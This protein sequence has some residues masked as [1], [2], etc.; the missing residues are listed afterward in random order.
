MPK[1]LFPLI[2]KRI[3]SIPTLPVTLH[4]VR[5]A[6]RRD[7]AGSSELA[8]LVE[9]DPALTAKVLRVMNSP[10]YEKRFRMSTL[11]HAVA[12]LG[13]TALGRLAEGIDVFPERD[14]GAGGLDPYAFWE[15]SLAVAAASRAIAREVGYD[16]PEEAYVGGLLHDLGVVVLHLYASEEDFDRVRGEVEGGV[17]VETAERRILGMDHCQVGALV[18]EQWRF[19]RILKDVIQFHHAE[20]SRIRS[21]DGRHQWMVGIVS[22]ANRICWAFGLGSKADAHRRSDDLPGLTGVSLKPEQVEAV[23]DAVGEDLERAL[24]LLEVRPAEGEDALGALRRESGAAAPELGAGSPRPSPASR[25]ALVGEV[26][27]RARRGHNMQD[28]LRTSLSSIQSGLGMDRLI[29]LGLDPDDERL[30]GKYVFDET[31][32]EVEIRGLELPLNPDGVIGAVLRDHRALLVDNWATD[33][34]LLGHLGV[35]EVAAAP[36]IVNQNSL[37]IVVVDSLFRNREITDLDV[38]LLG[39]LTTHL[40]LAV[41]NLL[42]DCQVSHLRALAAKDELTG[43]NNRRNLM[44]LLQKEIERA[45]RYSSPISVVMVD[46]DHFKRFNDR[47]GHQAGDEILAE[48]AQLIVAV[49]RDIDVIGRYGG[50]EFMVVL[51][52]THP[53]QAIVYAERLRTTIERFGRDSRRDY[54]ECELSISLG[55]TALTGPEDDLERM[56]H[57]VDQALYAA[58]ERGRN[59]VCVD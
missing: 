52:E 47:Y 54:P 48:V 1:S 44:K 35:V 11:T 34:A 56:I 38:Q 8:R 5:R 39:V 29:F 4:R 6:A 57:R 25:L 32:M 18:A 7:A 37:G 10:F 24:D 28:V 22:A 21:L 36:L 17:P 26:I 43:I 14:P 40:A 50:E 58:K 3:D 33:G 45:K 55:V 53:D 59:R 23:L 2:A 49:S 51:P 9:V 31:L 27:R 30:L 19:P 46:I 13:R 16:L 41:E 15:H 20:L 12:M 42:L